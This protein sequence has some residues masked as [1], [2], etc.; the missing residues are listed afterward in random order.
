MRAGRIT[1]LPSYTDIYDFFPKEVMLQTWA[2]FGVS[3]ATG[4]CSLMGET[5]NDRFPDVK[6]QGLE[7][8]IAACWSGK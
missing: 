4:S 3:M 6:V 5:L 1:E 8:F 7:A 2:S